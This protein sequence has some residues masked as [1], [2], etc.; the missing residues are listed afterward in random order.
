M[1]SLT[2][3]VAAG[4]L[5]AGTVTAGG[6]AFAS[7]S[8]TASG[9]GRAASLTAQNV[10]INATTGT[11]DLYPGFNDG[12]VHFTLT[13]TNPYAITFT[14]MAS[15]TV[16]SSDETACPASNVTVDSSKTGLT[17][18][19]GANT[20]SA[21]RSIADVVNMSHGAPDGCQGKFFT[22]ELTLA[23]NQD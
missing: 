12:D 15:G 11:T 8:S 4:L 13:N 19:V 9:S 14:S 20:T 5:A 6:M 18:A 1:K 21:A 10:T 2:L 23:G 3:K 22:I 7:W 17:L 16:T